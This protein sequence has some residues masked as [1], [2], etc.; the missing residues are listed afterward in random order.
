MKP[1]KEEIRELDWKSENSM[2][3]K[4]GEVFR[5]G[6]H[7][8]GSVGEDAEF[9]IEDLTIL[10][11]EDTQTEYLHPENL[12]KPGWTGGDAERGYWLFR[13]IT[14]GQTSLIIRV[15]FR[16][17]VESEHIIKVEVS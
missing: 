13:G 4:T 6:F 7:R 15:L 10:S 2:K 9:E 3:I 5:C 16:F 11:H 1:R 8:H 17:D 12:K 14:P